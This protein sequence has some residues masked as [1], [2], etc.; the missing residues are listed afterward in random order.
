MNP[1]K[2]IQTFFNTNTKILKDDL[3][4]FILKLEN[5]LGLSWRKIIRKEIIEQLKNYDRVISK[6]TQT[7]KSMVSYVRKIDTQIQVI[8]N[9]KKNDKSIL[10]IDDL[11]DLSFKEL[12][13]KLKIS[14]PK[15][16]EILSEK[17]IRFQEEKEQ[18]S[19][20]HLSILEDFILERQIKLTRLAKVP[21]YI[22]SHKKSKKIKG[23]KKKKKSNG[24]SIRKGIEVYD[25]IIE[26]GGVGKLIINNMRK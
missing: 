3:V 13:E 10:F 7:S 12:S 6:K 22:E 25:R 16:K 20:L 1:I 17:G 2:E 9:F 8:A 5:G 24:K 11:G 19:K 21:E 15:F 4:V 14:L 18:V 26:S 23:V